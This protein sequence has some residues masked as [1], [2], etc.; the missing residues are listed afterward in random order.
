MKTIVDAETGEILEVETENE[1]AERVL[2]EAVHIDHETFEIISS[3]LYY[4]EQFDIFKMKL[5]EAM[6]SNGIK[7][8]DND[9]FTAT[10]RA[11]SVQK[12]VDTERLKKDGL[13]EQYIKLIPQKGGLAIRFKEKV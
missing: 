2:T 7:K 10:I 12:R 13:Y 4:Q 9:Y 8:W 5:E 1:I 6:K 11:D 3:L